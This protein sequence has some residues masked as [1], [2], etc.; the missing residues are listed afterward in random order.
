MAECSLI[1]MARNTLNQFQNL[2]KQIMMTTPNIWVEPL[3]KPADAGNGSLN[4]SLS[5]HGVSMQCAFLINLAFRLAL[6]TS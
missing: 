3:R 2:D 1:A 4:I 6:V 5:L